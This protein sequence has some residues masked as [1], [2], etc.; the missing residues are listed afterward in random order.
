MLRFYYV[1]HLKIGIRAG[2]GK[3]VGLLTEAN[4]EAQTVWPLLEYAFSDLWTQSQGQCNRDV[5]AM[6]R[7]FSMIMLIPSRSA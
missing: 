5:R 7:L 6:N 2:E 4:T 3:I 1:S